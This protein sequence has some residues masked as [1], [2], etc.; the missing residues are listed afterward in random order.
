[1]VSPRDLRSSFGQYFFCDMFIKLDKIY[2]PDDDTPN[3]KNKN[4]DQV[5]RTIE[6]T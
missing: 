1:M 5:I 4:I 2:F 3:K 6:E